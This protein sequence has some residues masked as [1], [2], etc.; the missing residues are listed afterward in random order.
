MIE[1]IGPD[2]P[3]VTNDRGAKQSHLRYRFDL[4]DPRA[5]F[6]MARVL[7]EGAE[8]YGI[9]NWRGI[10]AQDHLAHALVHIYAWL[11]GDKSDDHLS[12]AMCRTMMAQA[13]E[14]S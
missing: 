5:M 6:E 9:D 10:P 8:K 3:V 12:H 11:A 14:L 4:M 7:S 13:M 2:A 1:G